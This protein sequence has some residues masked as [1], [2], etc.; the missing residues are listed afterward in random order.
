M[1][2]SNPGHSVCIRLLGQPAISYSGK[3]LRS[4]R[5]N[6]VIALLGYLLLYPR[7]HHRNEL[8]SLLWPDFEPDRAKHNLRQ[9]LT[10]LRSM[11]GPHAA[12]VLNVSRSHVAINEH[13]FESD[14]D[15]VRRAEAAPHAFLQGLDDEWVDEA[16]SALSATYVKAAAQAAEEH[17]EIDPKKAIEFANRAIQENPLIDLPRALKITAL[18]KL[19]RDNAAKLEYENFAALL[20]REIGSEP[21][22]IV[23]SALGDLER[24]QPPSIPVVLN[25]SRP[26]QALKLA[27]ALTPEWIDTGTL[28][29]G[30]AAA[31]EALHQARNNLSK[32]L[33]V[34]GKLCLAE[35]VFHQ[36]DLRRSG[37][38]LSEISDDVKDASHDLKAKWL[39]LRARR[40]LVRMRAS[41][42]VSI[43]NEALRHAQQTGDLYVVLDCYSAIASAALY[44]FDY[45]GALAA[46]N[47]VLSLAAKLGDDLAAGNA[48][49]RKAQVFD[50]QQCP[51]MAEAAARNAIEITEKL[52]TPAAATHR[53]QVA[54]TMENLGLTRE[55]EKGYRTALRE[56]AGYE[57][58]FGQILALTYLGDLACSHGSAKEAVELHAKAL[59]IR[60]GLGQNLGTATSLR[61]LGKALYK[62]NDLSGARE[63]LQESAALFEAEQALP[64]YASS[65]LAL[66]QVEADMGRFGS[67]AQRARE[68][69]SLLTAMGPGERKLIGPTG[70][71]SIREADRLLEQC[72]RGS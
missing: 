14:L 70:L 12:T 68:A 11:L 57:S 7:E 6:R 20:A 41:R 60:R 64:G 30:V 34:E 48:W 66:G 71:L 18:R 45:E 49:L 15:L 16:R 40:Q 50:A 63:A 27:I 55:A 22:R 62:T 46:T 44:S 31:E 43:A 5:S 59:K 25:S 33:I 29:L 39:L 69:R 37:E 53:L 23:E 28:S 72:H 8:A 51:E 10:Y 26:H 24:P 58:T 2:D 3:T 32:R 65:Q 36:G 54:R 21:G 61:G 67:A 4:F 35:L 9:T 56:L 38:I 19:G 42:A 52:I 1:P 13:A 47:Q 17:M